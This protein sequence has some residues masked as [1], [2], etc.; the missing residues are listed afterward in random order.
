MAMFL[1]K[2]LVL[3]LVFSTLTGLA[4]GRFLKAGEGEQE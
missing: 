1:G 4:V 3:Y 2:F